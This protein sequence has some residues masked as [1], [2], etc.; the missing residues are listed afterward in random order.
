MFVPASGRP[1]SVVRTLKGYQPEL[2]SHTL[3]L[4]ARLD[5]DGY[6]LASIISILAAEGAA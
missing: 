3:S 5:M 6:S 2:V 4:T 1:F